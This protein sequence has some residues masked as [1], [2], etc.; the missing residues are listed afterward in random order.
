[1]ERD[2]PEILKELRQERDLTMS[3]M[4]E[5]MNDRYGIKL[6][7]GT[8]S[9]WESG[10]TDPS[11]TM[12]KYVADYYNVSLDYLIGITDVKTPA[13]LL[14]YAKKIMQARNGGDGE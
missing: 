14:A 2:F 12:A 1:M 8:I 7:K 4:A 9:R 13:R 10:E 11:L 6:N 5:D 3:M